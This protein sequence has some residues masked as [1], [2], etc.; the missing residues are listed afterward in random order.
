M[1]Q[2]MAWEAASG[3]WLHLGQDEAPPRCLAFCGEVPAL[4]LVLLGGAREV[5]AVTPATAGYQVPAI[6]LRVSLEQ[7]LANWQRLSE[8]LQAHPQFYRV[9]ALGLCL[10]AVEAWLRTAAEDRGPTWLQGDLDAV[11]GPFDRNAPSR[12]GFWRWNADDR[13]QA[14]ADG[15]ADLHRLT[16]VMDFEELG[17][18]HR[19]FGFGTLRH[20][21]FEALGQLDGFAA[22][23]HP[24]PALPPREP[25]EHDPWWEHRYRAHA[26]GDRW[27]LVN[28]ADGTWR[29]APRWDAIQPD[30][31]SFIRVWVR[32]GPL[33][34]VLQIEP[35]VELLLAPQFDAVVD[36]A[37]DDQMVASQGGLLGLMH[38]PSGQWRLPPR[39]HELRRETDELLRAREGAHYGFLDLDGQWRVPP[40]YQQTRPF[41]GALAFDAPGLAWVM[42]EGRWGLLDEQGQ[43]RLACRYDQVEWRQEHD[44]RGWRVGR[45]GRQGWV[46]IDGREAVPCEW[47]EVDCY[48]PYQHPL[49]AEGIYRVTRNGL[50]GLL[51]ALGDWRV[52]PRY[53]EIEP[54]G[55]GQGAAPLPVDP[56]RSA[57]EPDGSLAAWIA[58]GGGEPGA[59]RLLIR[60][61][62]QQGCAVIDECERQWVPPSP[63]L[64]E[65]LGNGNQRWL[66]RT[67]EQ[68]RQ[69]LWSLARGEPALAGWHAGVEVLELPDQPL[70]L[71]FEHLDGPE[72]F[73]LGLRLWRETGESALEG[74]FSALA[75]QSFW[76]P[77]LDDDTREQLLKAWSQGQDVPAEA[78]GAGQAQ[79]CFVR[80][81]QPR[82]SAQAA[83]QARYQAGDLQAAL[84]L[85]RLA[86]SPTEA[87]A[88]ARRACALDGGTGTPSAGAW[89]QLTRLALQGAGGDDALSAA[90]DWVARVR[91]SEPELDEGF[92]ASA[93]E[94]RLWLEPAAGPVDGARALA[95]ADYLV[96]VTG[97]TQA[98]H[99]EG[100]YL[101]GRCHREGQ[102]TAVD[103]DAAREHWRI[104]AA[105]GHG[106][107]TRALVELLAEQ[108]SAEDDQAAAERLWLEARQHA[109]NYLEHPGDA[110][111]AAVITALH[112]F[113]GEL[114]L[115]SE[116]LD[117]AAAEYHLLQAAEAGHLPAMGLLAVEVYRRRGSPLRDG[118]QAR[119]WAL[120]HAEA[121]GA[122]PTEASAAWRWLLGWLLWLRG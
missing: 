33:W 78:W 79:P 107:A 95:A 105:D 108:A 29:E 41:G 10:G 11:S 88:W 117:W 55:L 118:R 35:S 74:C 65:T 36:S 53:T 106:A 80:P 109:W 43:E 3:A 45:D 75:G 116:P 2:G 115:L 59:P 8:W 54:L 12:S 86:A 49:Q 83:W 120:R 114:E 103:L 18:W 17:E 26:L 42:A 77:R 30:S 5:P 60:V 85:S 28:Q 66:K 101:L 96:A 97:T 38:I 32:Q 14:L 44:H 21:W 23:E 73:S 92:E 119:A 94:A 121:S 34:G 31:H 40:R 19:G 56:W 93:L 122:L 100:R 1:E 98:L 99:H 20:P 16:G 13:L 48:E 4:W 6:G 25:V 57:P 91:A 51:P 84:A 71:T 64:V 9:P 81:G 39:F 27:G 82:Q 46:G 67:D 7:A 50:H 111:D 76:L 90:R 52:A 110:G 68:D 47:D 37:C 87:Y 112:G 61:R 15:S 72:G 22:L 58:E 113:C 104:A 62:D 24:F 69:Q 63:G 70:L 89:L 102:G